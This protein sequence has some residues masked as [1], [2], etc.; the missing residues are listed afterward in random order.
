ML[1]RGQT[2]EERIAQIA[3]G[4]G[5]GFQNFQA[6]QDRQRALSLQEEARKRQ[7]A[8]QALEIEA[9]LAD[10]TGR[11]VIGSGLGS[12]ILKGETY[13]PSMIQGLGLSRK[14][15]REEAILQ[16]QSE[17][18]ALNKL[19]KVKKIEELSKPFEQTR[20]YQKA[21]T[22]ATIQGEARAEAEERKRESQ[23]QKK[24]QEANI[25]DFEIADPSVIPTTKD[26]EEI[27]KL[28]ASNKTFQEIGQ[29]VKQNVLKANPRDPRYYISNDW[30]TLQQDLTKMKLQAKNLEELGV[31]N[32]P[33]LSLV[34]ETLGGISPSNLAILGPEAAADRIKTALENSQRVLD[35][36]AAS[37]GYRPKSSTNTQ[38]AKL[39]R[40]AEL[41]AKLAGGA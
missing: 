23:L 3:Q 32:G 31:L 16:K 35:N 38:E 30:R 20:E 36:A 25:P 11:E 28:N 13:D 14:A 17:D 34:N 5:Q 40:L 27:K 6:Q 8:L 33:D 18:D 22:M 4:F 15:Q 24:M 12:K 39:K 41:E 9:K 10:T 29:R 26:A 7:E 21:A 37:R 1:Q 19:L 2:T